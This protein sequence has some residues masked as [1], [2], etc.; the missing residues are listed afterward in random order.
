MFPSTDIR[1]SSGLMTFRLRALFSLSNALLNIGFTSDQGTNVHRRRL[2]C[3]GLAW[4]LKLDA[5]SRARLALNLELE[6]S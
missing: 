2:Y 4:E 1:V 3:T 6:Y 5:L